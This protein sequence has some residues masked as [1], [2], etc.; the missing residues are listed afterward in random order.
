MISAIFSGNL[1]N[2]FNLN[3]DDR[4]AKDKKKVEN[5]VANSDFKVAIGK[6]EK[7]RVEIRDTDIKIQFEEYTNR[8]LKSKIDELHQEVQVMKLKVE[9]IKSHVENHQKGQDSI[10]RI[11]VLSKSRITAKMNLLHISKKQN[12]ET[13]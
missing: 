8:Q 13:K 7:W 12:D 5:K 4:F 10:K 6:K 11:D 3:L 9:N 1:L 2:K